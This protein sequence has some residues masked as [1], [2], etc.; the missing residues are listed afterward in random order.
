MKKLQLFSALAAICF[1]MTLVAQNTQ[2]YPPTFVGQSAAMTKTAPI[3]SMKA[4]TITESSNET[5][6]IP[7]NFK[8]NNQ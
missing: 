6:L 3:S 2:Q 1:T 4:P 5:F 7:N 8:A